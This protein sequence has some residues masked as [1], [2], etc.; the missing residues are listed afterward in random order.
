MVLSVSWFRCA[1]LGKAWEKKN[2]RK[3]EAK[4]K[5]C[6]PTVTRTWMPAYKHNIDSGAYFYFG[7]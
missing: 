3:Q 5:R 1:G 7:T 2:E 4:G 6:C